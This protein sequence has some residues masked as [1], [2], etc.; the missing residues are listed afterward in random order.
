M[1]LQTTSHNFSGVLELARGDEAFIESF[2]A[3]S[4]EDLSSY[5]SGAKDAVA[6]ENLHWL[7]FV[8]HKS[9]TLFNL[10]E[11]QSGA[12]TLARM[13]ELAK[14]DR[15]DMGDKLELLEMDIM[16]LI[17]NINTELKNRGG[18]S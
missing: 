11:Y 4:T 18:V 5:L 2:I 9:E 1:V 13:V 17:K 6:T 15:W 3:K 12:H 14:N 8:R 16:S 7:Q 10:L